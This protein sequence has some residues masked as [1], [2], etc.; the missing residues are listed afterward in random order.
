MTKPLKIGPWVVAD[1]LQAIYDY[2]LPLSLEKAERIIAEYDSIVA[3]LELN[4][5][6]F[7]PR[8][9]GW[10]MY[11]FDSGPYLLY[12]TELESFWLVVGIFHASH[13]PPSP[14]ISSLRPPPSKKPNN[15]PIRA[16]EKRDNNQT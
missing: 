11:P 8:S 14:Q 7:H 10:R 16:D 5:L 12:Y 6:L 4:P 15:P 1:D 2:H 9:N 13:C 3:V